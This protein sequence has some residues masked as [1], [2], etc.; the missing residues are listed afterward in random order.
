MAE[1]IVSGSRSKRD[2]LS[3]VGPMTAYIAEQIEATG[4]KTS[5]WCS[6]GCPRRLY[7]LATRTLLTGCL[8]A[9]L[10][11]RLTF[12]GW[13][14]VGDT[15]VR[16]SGRRLVFGGS[17]AN[18]FVDLNMISTSLGSRIEILKDC[19]SALYWA[20]AVARVLIFMLIDCSLRQTAVPVVRARGSG[21]FEVSPKNPSSTASRH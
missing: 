4:L 3:D 17:G 10:P 9:G 19:K 8:V 18:N 12:A 21:I 1:V 7:L 6:A 13:V 16:I 11:C 15:L 20:D 2:D 5:S 14:S